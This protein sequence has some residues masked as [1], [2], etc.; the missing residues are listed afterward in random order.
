MDGANNPS[1]HAGNTRTPRGGLVAYT[2]LSA[3]LKLNED[4][5]TP[6]TQRHMNMSTEVARKANIKKIDH[7]TSRTATH[8]QK[9]KEPKRGVEKY[10]F[11][12]L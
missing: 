5:D 11:A 6:S 4:S 10:V 8:Q 9:V 12:W 7:Q 1:G 3:A 2:P